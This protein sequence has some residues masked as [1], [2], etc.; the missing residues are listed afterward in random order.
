[1]DFIINEKVYGEKTLLSTDRQKLEGIL[2]NLIKNAIKFTKKGYVELGNKIDGE[3]I[4]FY[5]KDTGIGIPADR[6]D[7]IFE[8]FTQA[9]MNLTRDYEGSGLGLSIVKAYVESLNGDVWVESMPGEGS[10]FYFYLP[11]SG[12][13]ENHWKKTSTLGP[14]EKIGLEKVKILIA[15]D[16]ANSYKYIETVLNKEGINVIHTINGADTVEKAKSDEE[17]DLILMDMRMPVMDGYEA[18]KRIREFNKEIPII[19]QTAFAFASDKNNVMEAGCT[20]FISK[21]LKK[22]ELLRIINKYLNIRDSSEKK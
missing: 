12:I 13:S 6:I 4:L 15:E 21:P 2:M 11:Y 17:I 19:A 20:D 18:T 7:A 3:K 9:D 22:T 14:K 8:R 1:M 10:T 16:D 5:V